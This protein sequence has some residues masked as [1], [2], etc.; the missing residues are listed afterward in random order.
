VRSDCITNLTPDGLKA[1]Q[2]Y[3]ISTVI[4]LRSQSERAADSAAVSRAEGV[5]YLHRPLV[6]DANMRRL[7]EATDMFG[8]YLMMLD[9]DHHAFRNVFSAMATAEGGVLFHCFAGKDR[10]GL[11]AAMLLSLAGVPPDHIAADFNES[12]RQ[13]ARKYEEWIAGAEPEKRD[14]M[15][16]DLHC[17][18]ERILGVLEYLDRKWGGVPSY[19][20]AAG[21]TPANIDRVAA[22]LA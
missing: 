16:E 13:L 14:Q 3:G 9:N 20:E 7:G 4:D 5:V 11:V 10:T 8:R 19:L 12:D 6:D 2:D 21:M 22:K 15:R 18:P 1:M 17:P